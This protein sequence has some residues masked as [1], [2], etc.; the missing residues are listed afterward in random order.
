MNLGKLRAA[1]NGQGFEELFSDDHNLRALC[2]KYAGVLRR[3]KNYFG[4]CILD[5]EL[6]STK[7]MFWVK[8][9]TTTTSLHDSHLRHN[10]PARLVETKRHKH[11]RSDSTFN[12]I[13]RKIR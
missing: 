8:I 11:L 9:D 5:N 7:R 4:L 10:S 2:P 12:K 13:T 1:Q 3:Y 6:Q